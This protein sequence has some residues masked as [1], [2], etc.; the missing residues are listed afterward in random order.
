M[1]TKYNSLTVQKAIDIL[2]LFKNHSKLSFTD[3]QGL[4][5][6]NKSTLSRL[7]KTLEYNKFLHRDKHGRYSVG[8]E[9]FVLGNQFSRASH[10]KRV[11][12]PFLKDLSQ[13]LNHTIHLG[14]LDGT[15]IVIIDKHNP[16][17]NIALLSRVGSTVPAHCT[18]QGKTLLA[19]SSLSLVETVIAKHGLKAFTPNTITT[20]DELFSELT[21]IRS[22]GY[23]IDN[24]EHERH[25]RCVA[26]PLLN[27]RT[28]T[29]EA[30]ISATGLTTEMTDDVSV[31]T[32]EIFKEVRDK[33]AAELGFCEMSAQ[34]G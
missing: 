7:L 13:K 29:V 3:I 32:A 12:A 33:I 6:Y 21:K 34:E 31:A 22:Q 15:E 27:C 24:S 4:L 28:K 14:I 9:I 1:N 18:G 2:K 26:V 20:A 19:F 8:L 16:P 23:A 30:A 5:G 25:T 17:N 10:V 11:A